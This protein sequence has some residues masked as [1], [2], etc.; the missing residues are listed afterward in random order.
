MLGTTRTRIDECY[1]TN[2]G[3][4]SNLQHGKSI[5]VYIILKTDTKSIRLQYNCM[6]NARMR[7]E[8]KRGG[9]RKTE[10]LLRRG[11]RVNWA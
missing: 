6:G 9:N 1:Y 4:C 2:T 11:F 3:I 10:K 7:Y 5:V 8:L